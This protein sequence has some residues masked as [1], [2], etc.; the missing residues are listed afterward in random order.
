VFLFAGAG[1]PMGE[2]VRAVCRRLVELVARFTP[3]G[4]DADAVI[5]LRAVFQ[6]DHRALDLN[7]MPAELMPRKGRFGIVDYEKMFC[8]DPRAD[9]FA[10]RRIDRARGALVLVRPDQY[11]AQVLPPDAVRELADFLGGILIAWR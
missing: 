6:E 10:L 11:V 5:D 8:A 4:A 7:R 2:A 1:N 3:E 9:I